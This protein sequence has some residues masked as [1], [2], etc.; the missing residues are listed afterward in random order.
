VFK[1]ILP[2]ALVLGVFGLV[3]ASR[4]AYTGSRLSLRVAGLKLNPISKAAITV[5]II[6]PTGTPLQLDAFVASIIYNGI[7]IATIDYRDRTT[8]KATGL[9]RIDIPIR[10]SPLG[11][12]QLGNE[13][14]K[15]GVNAFKK[16]KF[17]IQGTINSEGLSIPFNQSFGV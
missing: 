11:A 3:W 12:I 16:F 2:L 15:S 5:D 9:M 7:D 17:D 13:I 14:L 10:I 8:L 6:N 1:Q 4:K